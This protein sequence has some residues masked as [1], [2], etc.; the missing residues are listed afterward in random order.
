MK[1]ALKF[2]LSQLPAKAHGENAARIGGIFMMFFSLFWG[3]LPTIA[4]ITA[5]ATGNFKPEML[6][7]LIFSIIGTGLFL[8]GLWLTTRKIETTLHPDRVEQS[9]RSIF[10]S[11]HWNEP[12]KNYPGILYRSEYH[13]GGKNSS[14]Y[15][16][17]IIELHH[18]EKQKR[19]ILY[20]SRNDHGIRQIW[21]DCCRQLNMPALQDDA[22]S[23]LVRDAEDLDKSVKEL[24]AEGKIK[25]KFDPTTPPPSGIVVTP[26]QGQ[27]RIEIKSSAM[28]WWGALLAMAIPSIFVYVG[29]FG[30]APIFFGI[31]GTIFLAVFGSAAFW[32]FFTHEAMELDSNG[33][34]LLRTSRNGD[35]IKADIESDDVESVAIG[36]AGQNNQKTV[37]IETNTNA[38]K[39]GAGL[40]D[41]ALVWLRDCILAVLTR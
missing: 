40:K 39:I 20:S 11:K 9:V 21:E 18:P 16:L 13:S 23:L 34:R 17:Y 8:T 24:A 36:N 30:D 7:M 29:F 4:L 14:S 35:K 12:I 5:L 28:P 22:G 10:G 25:V 26:M 2:D 33:I 37:R 1:N 38:F 27:L 32:N 31:I 3:G 41:D 19:I 15:T 6:F